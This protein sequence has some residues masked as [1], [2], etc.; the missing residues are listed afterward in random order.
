MS[1]RNVR[2]LLIEDNPG[3]ADL[4]RE[5][6]GSGA[7]SFAIELVH[8]ETLAAGLAHVGDPGRSAVDVVLLDLSLPDSHGLDSIAR[9]VAAAPAIPV[10]VLTGLD[11]ETTALRAVQEGAQDYLLKGEVT[12]SALVRA[13]RYAIERKRA[14]EV[15]RSLVREQAARAEAEK[16]KVE[17]ERLYRVL[18]DNN[19]GIVA[20]Y[21]ELD[22]KTDSLRRSSEV[23]SRVVS[24]VSHE[25]RTPLNSILGL[26]RLLLSGSEGPL[27]AEQQKQLGFILKSSLEL[28]Q[29]VDE[30]LDLSQI[31]AG[32]VRLHVSEIGVPDLFAAMRGVSR[33]LQTRE[34]VE[35]RFE[36]APDL[37]ALHTDDGKITQVLRNL[38]SNALKFT[39]T[40]RVTVSA[41]M[42]DAGTIVF[43][44]AD[45]G[46]GIAPRDLDRVF[47]EFTQLENRLQRGV[48]GNGLGLS[49]SLKLAELLGGT[50]R[51]ESEPGKGSA[52]HLTIPI[53]HPEAE[54]MAGL[55]KRAEVIADDRQPI[56]VVEDDRQTLFLYEKY[57]RGSGFQ[58][59]PARTIDQAKA[60]IARLRP[61]AIV[62][63]IMLDGEA[64]WSFLGELKS[65]AATRDIPVLVVT[66]TDRENKARALGADE[67]WMK[68]MDPA[69]LLKKLGTLGRKGV[70]VEKILVIDDDEVS[71][72]LVR[73]ILA[74][75]QY[76]VIEATGGAEGVRLAREEL[77]HAILLD[78]VMPGMSAFEVLDEL[79]ANPQTRSIPVIIHTSKDLGEEERVRL[80]REA[81]AILNKQSLSREIA[82]GRIR[83]ALIL[84]GVGDPARAARERMERASDV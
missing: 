43:T 61:A 6:L 67:F 15:G 55:A 37:P 36:E 84:A 74:E 73:R 28:S 57:L 2:A 22:E 42:R 56:L 71:R 13:V 50:L 54:E 24:N 58:V 18:D 3:D 38:I 62:L 44:V 59:V 49:L 25:F 51:A 16:A 64:S 29:L 80:S 75:T 9:L 17:A 72:Y 83:E 77:P 7:P 23:K 34:A 1:P 60:V 31:E 11:D 65:K 78:F 33:P 32:K 40:G 69:W 12:R 41:Q 21:N 19:R 8:E 5:S 47:E 30:L 27:N 63:D 53:L 79:K 68:P 35:L 76:R 26:S 81:T 4:I 10:V 48:K 82:I 70:P 20:L 14:E 39:E 45:T 46:I 52:F 66:V